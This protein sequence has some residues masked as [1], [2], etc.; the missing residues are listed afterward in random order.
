MLSKKFFT[1]ARSSLLSQP[2][3]SFQTFGKTYQTGFDRMLSDKLSY[4]RFGGSWFALF[5]VL[6]AF[7]FGAS[8]FMAPDRYRYHFAYTGDRSSAVRALKSRL[9]GNNIANVGWTAP[10]L[11]GVNWYLSKHV[12]SLVL[13]KLFFLSLASSYIFLSA[14]NPQ[15]GLSRGPLNG[16]LPRFNSYAEDGSYT[17]GA[18]Q[19]AQALGY[20]ALLYFGWWRLSAVMM[21]YDFLDLGPGTLGGPVAAIAGFLMFA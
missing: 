2:P 1:Q 7:A 17:M 12:S 18:D 19:M 20:F 14:F 13:T 4:F 15:T 5:G 21:T 16:Y 9:G 8:L 10:L 11:I 3:R 6:N